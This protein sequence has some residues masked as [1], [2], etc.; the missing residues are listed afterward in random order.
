MLCRLWGLHDSANFTIEMVPLMEA[1]CSG[2]IMDWADILSDKLAKAILNFRFNSRVTEMFIPPFYYSA[3]VL[4]VLCFN[5]EFPVLGWRW[6]SQ[7]PTPIHI[8][9]Q[10]LWKTNYK[11]HLYQNLQRFHVANLLIHF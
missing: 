5:S 4:D 9:H 10:K 7:D 2:R 3:N 11:H 8:Y 6:T 1:A